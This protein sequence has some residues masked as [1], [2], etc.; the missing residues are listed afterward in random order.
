MSKKFNFAIWGGIAIVG[1]YTFYGSTRM[2]SSKGANKLEEALKITPIR[3]KNLE[4]IKVENSD[5]KTEEIF[6]DINKPINEENVQAS[7]PKPI[8]PYQELRI[9][10]AQGLSSNT[11][12]YVDS[13]IK[14][15]KNVVQEDTGVEYEDADNPYIQLKQNSQEVPESNSLNY[16]ESTT[17]LVPD[18]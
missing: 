14:L 15:E 17:S 7:D 6:K 3:N 5:Q 13:T 12:V 1:I 11:S 9:R 10:G 4:I 8:D 18:S 16:I 2:D